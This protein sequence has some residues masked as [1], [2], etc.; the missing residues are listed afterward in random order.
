M[1]QAVNKN[2]A[3]A[4]QRLSECISA[5]ISVTERTPGR[6]EG[7]CIEITE[8]ELMVWFMVF[9]KFQVQLFVP[10]DNSTQGVSGSCSAEGR[11]LLK[12]TR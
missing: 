2:Q 10:S 7:V 6:R 4:S 5:I 1:A 8:G 11:I 12:A 9:I 3:L